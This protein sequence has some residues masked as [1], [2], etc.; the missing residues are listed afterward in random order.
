M[1]TDHLKRVLV[2]SASCVCDW[3]K[4][5]MILTRV[6]PHRLRSYYHHQATAVS[7]WEPPIITPSSPSLPSVKCSDQQ[8]P[9]LGNAAGVLGHDAYQGKTAPAGSHPDT[10]PAEWTVATDAFGNEFFCNAATGESSWKHP[11]YNGVGDEADH[12]AAEEALED[13]VPESAR[14][15]ASRSSATCIVERKP[16]RSSVGM[17]PQEQ[18][19]GS[20]L[21]LMHHGVSEPDASHVLK[22]DGN[23]AE[24][25]E[26]PQV[27]RKS[28]LGVTLPVG[29]EVIAPADREP[30]YYHEVD[31]GVVQWESPL[32]DR[33]HDADDIWDEHS[34]DEGVPYWNNPVTGESRWLRP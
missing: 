16:K 1:R 30:C 28:N 31:T 14:R 4:K 23:L 7:Q 34:T 10:S 9:G 26:D 22:G 6:A 15:S 3:G 25:E 18:K 17:T 24:V 19:T 5:R 27:R 33:A 2:K 32:E 13:Q 8:A 12:V 11:I 29:W 20:V 21:D